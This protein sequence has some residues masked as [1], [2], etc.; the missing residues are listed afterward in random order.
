M[1]NALNSQL[2]RILLVSGFLCILSVECG[3]Q[4]RQ[5]V[6]SG[7]SGSFD[8]RSIS[9]VAV[10]VGA[11]RNEGFAQRSCVAK[12]SWDK[13]DL[14]V[15]SGA[16][17]IDVDAM[18]I[19]LDL[20][21][22]VVALQVKKSDV[23]PLMK[24]E[25]YALQK[26]PRLLRT[27]T[28]GDFYSAADTDL[29]GRVEIWTSDAGAVNGFENLPLSALD[30]APTVVLRFERQRLMDVSS[31]FQSDFDRQ[32]AS[33][34]SQLDAQQL[35]DF[36]SS[37]GTLSA[38]TPLSMEQLRGLLTTKVKVLEIVWSYLYSGREQEAWNALAALWPPADFNRIRASILN[39]RAR[40]IR[41]Q[42]DGV[43]SRAAASHAKKHAYIFDPVPDNEPGIPSDTPWGR[44][45]QPLMSSTNDNM[46]VMRAD[47]QPADIL[48]MRP[49]PDSSQA[50]L[51]MGGMMDL[52]IDAAGKVRSATMEG[53]H[54][55]DLIN[56]TAGWKFIPAFKSGHP[57]ASRQRLSVTPTQ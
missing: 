42:V 24:Y 51:R 11:Q 5:V 10:F 14:P 54:D 50:S 34:R 1:S 27:I 4:P 46:G 57:V 12:L 33:A 41:S 16:S 15:E 8:A 37:D 40:G 49:P 18:G 31:E 43:S 3:C 17:Q 28:G 19:D 30:F 48:L 6:C 22:L 36:K 53:R 21:S 38:I 35:S 26:P 44:N 29:D 39:A 23:D 25:I 47:T 7:G 20:G 32:I 9:G 45:R 55:K 52:V 13:Q 2:A 56:A